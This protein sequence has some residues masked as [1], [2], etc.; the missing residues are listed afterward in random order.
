MVQKKRN[1]GVMIHQSDEEI[2]KL[3][4]KITN[5][6]IDEH[7]GAWGGILLQSEWMVNLISEEIKTKLKNEVL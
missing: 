5:R 6:I 4:R 2:R 1:G 7:K 3:A